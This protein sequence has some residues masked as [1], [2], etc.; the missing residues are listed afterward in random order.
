MKNITNKLINKTYKLLISI[1]L[2]TLVLIGPSTI[3]L[4]YGPNYTNTTIFL[5]IVGL[6]FANIIILGIYIAIYK[7]TLIKDFKD[8]FLN[9]KLS[10]NLELAFKYWL[11]GFIVMVAS[12][13]LINILTQSTIAGNEEAVRKL[14]DIAPIYMLFDVAI[15]APLVEELTFRKSIRDWI[16]NKKIYILISGLL[17]G[18]LHV[19]GSIKA[20]SDILF[21]IP[22]SA[23]GISFAKLYTKSNN[24]F[25]SITMHAMHNTLAIL[26]Y[27]FV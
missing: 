13:L 18:S 19:I 8:F 15:Y 3:T 23:L 17:F 21:I 26:L 14:I 20:M 25:S 5:K 24:I 27:L 2:I 16:N 6:I 10:N 4:L 12:N 1:I 7:D 11:I 22:Y 9:K